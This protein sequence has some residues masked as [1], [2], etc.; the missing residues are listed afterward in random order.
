MRAPW[1][2]VGSKCE[3][4]LARLTNAAHAVLDAE[5]VSYTLTGKVL[6]VLEE[7]DEYLAGI[8]AFVDKMHRRDMGGY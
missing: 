6:D 5:P 8:G 4:L 1:P 2:I 3:Q 7:A